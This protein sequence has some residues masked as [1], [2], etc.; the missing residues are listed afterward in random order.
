MSHD[1]AEAVI[2]VLANT[3]IRTLDIT[4][5]APEMNP[6]F[7][8]LVEN[9]SRLN[10]RIIDRSNL[11]ILVANGFRHLPSFLAAH[12]V[13]VVA[14]LPCYLEQNCD[15]QRGSGVFKR[16]LE[17]LRELNALGY[18]KPGSGLI[19]NL[20]YNPIGPGLPPDQQS[21]QEA[22]RRELFTRYGIE[23]TNLHVITN[24]P[25]SR[26][27]EDL[28]RT[29][30]FETYMQTLIASF[31][32]RTVE[33]LMCRGM[34]SVDWEGRLFDC[35]F[36]QMLDLKLDSH[37]PQTIHEFDVGRLRD[38]IIRTGRHCF[39]CAAGCGSSCQGSL[40]SIA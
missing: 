25:I 37:L 34:I 4:G 16:S 31:N 28:L 29:G 39:G 18:G 7:G 2:Q 35:D 30:Q 19:L 26:Y 15:S 10:R 23:F 9:A 38:R 27:L 33:N 12:R 20:V 11:T 14:S 36:N 22:Y 17:A 32:S 40:V 3:D 1:T 21:L 13:E 8:Y 5:G 6:Q 24:M